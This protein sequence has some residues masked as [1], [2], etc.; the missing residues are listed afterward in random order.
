MITRMWFKRD[1]FN[2]P[3]LCTEVALESGSPVVSTTSTLLSEEVY[4]H[5]VPDTNHF[6]GE[7]L[8]EGITWEKPLIL[9]LKAS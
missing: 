8:S 2:Q 1:E 7:S 4:D 6:P 3:I 9:N 5:W